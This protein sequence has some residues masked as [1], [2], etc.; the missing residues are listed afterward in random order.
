MDERVGSHSICRRDDEGRT[1]G[2]GDS[3]EDRRDDD[4]NTQDPA[5]EN[6]V[7][8]QDAIGDQENSIRAEIAI[9]S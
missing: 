2:E 3:P 6:S 5:P 8:P 4:F 7:K 9:R 1:A